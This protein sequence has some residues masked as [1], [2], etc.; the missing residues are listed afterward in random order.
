MAGAR[1]AAWFSTLLLSAF[2]LLALSPLAPS[3]EIEERAGAVVTAVSARLHDA[4]RPFADVLLRAGQIEELSASNAALRREVARLQVESATLREQLTAAEQQAALID[5]VGEQTGGVLAAT[6]VLRDPSPGRA[7][8][9]INRGAV[10]GVLPGQPV[11]GQ[12]AAL[13][14]VVTR[15]D[16]RRA[17]FRLLTDERSAVTAIV[18]QSRTPGALSGTGGGLRLEFVRVG[19]EVAVGDL[20]L[21]A[22][23]GGLLPGALPIGRVTDVRSSDQD[24]FESITVEPLADLDRLEHVLVMIDVRPRV[25]AGEAGTP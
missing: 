23:L 3:G 6:V 15:T 18:Q 1:T 17:W 20:V 16:E 11:L 7:E 13:V 24:L 2:A 22:T 14:G 12:G 10:D 9:M 21:T 8:L 25:S 5:A 19:A 4:V